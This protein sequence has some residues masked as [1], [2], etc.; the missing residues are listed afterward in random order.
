MIND[1][2]LER[3]EELVDRVMSA[4]KMEGANIY[5]FRMVFGPCRAKH[6]VYAT[7]GINGGPKINYATTL[8]RP[9][10]HPI[11]PPDGQLPRSG[12]LKGP[13]CF[14]YTIEWNDDNTADPEA[15]VNELDMAVEKLR[16]AA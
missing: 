14:A 2:T 11:G 13:E 15:T 1:Q 4:Q 9:H 16:T 8:L 10:E 12:F 6:T 5:A 7:Y 3:L